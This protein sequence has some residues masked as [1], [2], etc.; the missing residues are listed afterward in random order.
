MAYMDEGAEVFLQCRHAIRTRARRCSRR[1]SAPGDV[2][3][4]VRFMD[5]VRMVGGIATIPQRGARPG[6]PHPRRR[7]RRPARALINRA[8]GRL[9]EDYGAEPGEHRHDVVGQTPVALDLDLPG[10]VGRVDPAAREA[11]EQA[12]LDGHD[13]LG[14]RDGS[15]PDVD[16]VVGA[17]EAERVVAD[18]QLAGAPRPE[19]RVAAGGALDDPGGLDGV[20][21]LWGRPEA[22]APGAQLAEHGRERPAGI[23]Q[24]VDGD[25]RGAREGAL[26]DDAV[27]LQAGQ[28][29]GEDV[30]ADAGQPVG[31]VGEPLG[32]EQQLA[33]DE[34]RPALADDVERDRG[35]TALTVALHALRRYQR[36]S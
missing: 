20:P 13:G 18:A 28:A 19:P 31:Q 24:L 36:E 27:L 16:A 34:R 3:D 29:V 9:V 14:R 32:A 8:A 5:V 10:R 4:D 7:A 26:L 2:R 15:G 11:Q 30:R 1:R 6:R 17:G 22:R 25:R 33:D 23:G 21:G 12:R 35:R